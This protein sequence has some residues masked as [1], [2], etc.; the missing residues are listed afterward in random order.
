MA[1]GVTVGTLVRAERV[2]DLKVEVVE[3][4]E[5]GVVVLGAAVDTTTELIVVCPAP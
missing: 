4:A 1:T 3:G 5:G 2:M